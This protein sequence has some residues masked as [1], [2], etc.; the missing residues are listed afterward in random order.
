MALTIEKAGN[1]ELRVCPGRKGNRRSLGLSRYFMDPAQGQIL[2]VQIGDG[3]S[4]CGLLVRLQPQGNANTQL[5][6]SASGPHVGKEIKTG[7]G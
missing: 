5:N 7:A 2:R 3:K 4:G 6:R 1:W